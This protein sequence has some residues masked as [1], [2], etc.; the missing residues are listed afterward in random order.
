MNEIRTRPALLVIDVQRGFLSVPE[1]RPD[2]PLLVEKINELI[3]D[4]HSRDLP[5]VHIMTTHGDEG[6]TGDLQTKENGKIS[7][8]RGTQDAEEIEDVHRDGAD[9]VMD[10]MRHSAFVRTGLEK[11]LWDREVNTVVLAG[12]STNACMGLTAIDAYER[13]IMPVLAEEA[14]LGI[15]P[16]REEGMLRVLKDGYSIEPV[17]NERIRE[18]LTGW[19]PD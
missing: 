6:N 10:K 9:I 5:V 18:L 1:P 8:I 4:F 15:D 13:D 12:L 19:L 17:S 16:E 3:D 14:I 11:A 7:F 2:F